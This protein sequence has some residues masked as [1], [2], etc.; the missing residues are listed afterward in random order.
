MA[1]SDLLRD[2]PFIVDVYQQYRASLHYKNGGNEGKSCSDLHRDNNDESQQV[3]TLKEVVDAN[4]KDYDSPTLGPSTK[5]EVFAMVDKVVEEFESSKKRNVNSSEKLMDFLAPSFSFGVTQDFPAVISLE[6]PV[7]DTNTPVLGSA[8]QLEPI[9]AVLLSMCKWVL[10]DEDVVH[11][12]AKRKYTKSQVARTKASRKQTESLVNRENIDDGVVDA[13]SEHLNSLESLRAENSM[14]RFFLPTF[15]VV[16]AIDAKAIASINNF[17]MVVEIKNERSGRENMINLVDLFPAVNMIDSKNNLTKEGHY[18]SVIVTNTNDMVVAS[19]LHK[20][21]CQYLDRLNPNKAA[22]LLMVEVTR[23]KF[24]WQ[25][26][27]RPNNSGVFLM[28]HM[29]AYMG[30][31][32]SKWSYGLETEGKKLNILLGHLQKK[33]VASL[34]FSE[35]NLHRDTIRAQ[36]DGI[37]VANIPVNKMKLP[38]RGK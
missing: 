26:D 37:K 13:W 16:F 5:K 20:S 3:S 15:I 34:L 35:C 4:S 10:T 30:T 2:N 7:T 24:D 18:K 38:K 28:C 32:F 23:E 31:A 33:Y 1:A 9:K 25:T 36:L 12:C 11:G 27:K 17:L 8:H 19:V 6:I 14:S 29:E 21:F 22:A